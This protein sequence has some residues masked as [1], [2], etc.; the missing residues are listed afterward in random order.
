MRYGD[1]MGL[2]G[3]GVGHQL[4]RRIGDF[5]DLWLSTSSPSGGWAPML[6]PFQ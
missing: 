4:A 6:W 5:G 3:L 2:L 1:C